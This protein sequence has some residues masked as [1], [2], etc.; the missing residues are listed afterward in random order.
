MLTARGLS[1]HL[2][3]GTSA[4]RNWHRVRPASQVASAVAGGL[5]GLQRAV[6][7][8]PLDERCSVVPESLGQ[9]GPVITPPSRDP[10]STGPLLLGLGTRMRERASDLRG[11]GL[12]IYAGEG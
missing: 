5:P 6:P 11:T 1:P 8:A 7:S 3:R 2:P 4:G 12:V 9:G 10:R